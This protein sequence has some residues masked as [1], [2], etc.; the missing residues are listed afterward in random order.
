MLPVVQKAGAQQD[1]IRVAVRADSLVYVYHSVTPPLGYGFNIYRQDIP[2]GEFAKLNEEPIYGARFGGEFGIQAESHLEELRATLKQSNVNEILIL[3][4]SDRTRG[5]LYTYAYPEIAAALGRL[6]IDPKAP[7]GRR[8]T[9]EVRTTDPFG[10]ETG[11][12]FRRTVT[13][14][15]QRP[16]QPT[17]LRATNVEEQITLSWTY[18]V[19]RPGQD[20]K[21]IRFDVYRIVPG[22]AEPHKVNREAIFRNEAQ[23]QS[24][25]TFRV[26][27][28]GIEEQFFVR[29]VDIT[30]QVG[31]PS[32]TLRFVVKDTVAPSVPSD[33][34]ATVLADGRVEI[35]WP[36]SVEH[37]ARGYH[38]YRA[39]SL[40]QKAPLQRLTAQPL[41]ILETVFRDTTV[42][43]ARQLYAYRVTALDHSGNESRPSNAAVA[44]IE[45]QT[46]PPAPLT[47]QA[48]YLKEK[49]VRLTWQP[50]VPM[51]RDFQTYVIMRR[52]LMKG[53]PEVPL[54]VNIADVTRTTYLDTG[55]PKEGFI[56]GVSYLYTV[57]SA[58]ST[59]NISDS[60]TV[61]ITIPKATAPPP[62]TAV[63]A[64][65]ENG[66]R[67]VVTWSPPPSL[68]IAGYR[69]YRQERG[70]RD[71]TTF[72][73]DAKTLTFRDESVRKPATYIY[74]VTAL[75]SVGNESKP[76]A[77]DTVFLRDFTP[78]RQVRNVRA[79]MTSRGA[80]VRWEP[81]PDTSIIG[82]RV[83]R[84]VLATGIYELLTL[85]PVKN[86]EWLD[87]TGKENAWYR[88]G[89]V[90]SST[91][92]GRPSEPAQVIGRRT[93]GR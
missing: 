43:G 44:R 80:L 70:M 28:T 73:V 11:E 36:V 82:Y 48:E 65:N 24:V 30:G 59:R 66:I 69:I 55:D 71:R 72:N 26:P 31:P 21:V 19:N 29:A 75:D 81:L 49:R 85:T 35:T 76:S 60:V 86:T 64:V 13:L 92:E 68:D 32:Q 74:W 51:P 47:L 16:V 87:R 42:G 56:E 27:S 57:A 50:R 78:P 88:V 2:R 79:E 37:D 3:L 34:E 67:A 61:V 53:A 14:T 7:I 15:P 8:V 83:Y 4:R 10:N 40:E 38:V 5:L 90:D 41:G 22:G 17:N 77:A 45:D 46:P 18:P 84:S 12:S 6:Y 25:L 93:Q 20:D 23:D 58:D 63:S 89:A 54:R 33:V 52:K 9:Y 62:P 1:T 91:N 39:T